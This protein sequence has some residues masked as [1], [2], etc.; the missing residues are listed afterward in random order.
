MIVIYTYPVR[1]TLSAVDRW[2]VLVD[3][4]RVEFGE[5]NGIISS[6][7]VA[8]RLDDDASLPKVSPSNNP[9]VKLHVD[10]GKSAHNEEVTDYLMVVQGMMCLLGT[11]TIDFNKRQVNW[12]PEN[13]DERAKLGLFSYSV[14]TD[15][16]V[17]DQSPFT[18]DFIARTVFTAASSSHYEVPLTFLRRGLQ[19]VRND[20]FIDAFYN[21]FF[22]LET[23]FAPGFSNPKVVVEKLLEASSVKEALQVTRE[24]LSKHRGRLPKNVLVPLLT[25]G[26]R[27]LITLLVDTRGNLHHHAL[28]RPGIWHPERPERFEAE[29]LILQ[30]IAHSIALNE[31]FSLIYS[32]DQDDAFIKGARDVGAMFKLEAN[33]T[34]QAGKLQPFNIHI[35]GRRPHYDMVVRA[36]DEVRN[37]LEAQRP[38]IYPLRY[39]IGTTPN[40][41]CASYECFLPIKK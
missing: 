18:F 32:Q 22:F 7:S 31:V 27:E 37:M 19:D 1:S 9:N 12:E 20:R 15:K 41:V 16:D 29:A 3:K 39:T 5:E 2:P 30:S 6:V 33:I 13:D 40:V 4:F 8:V 36:D 17:E 25:L 38:V 14:T 28:R 21:F 24:T 23:Q 26:D 34:T 35:P 10:V 11:F